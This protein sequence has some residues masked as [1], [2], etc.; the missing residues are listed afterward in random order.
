M[1]LRLTLLGTGTPTPSLERG[2]GSFLVEHDDDA[3]LF[4]CG[5]GAVRRLLAA[6]VPPTRVTHLFLTHLHYDH[7]MDYAYLTLTRWDQ[8]AGQIPDLEVYGPAGTARMTRLLFGEEGAYQAD[9]AGRTLHP[10]SHII[11]EHRGG[12][13]PRHRPAPRVREVGAGAAIEGGGWQARTAEMVHCQPYLQSVAYRFESPEGSIVVTGD[14]APNPQ[15]VELARG[16]NVLL[17]MCHFLNDVETDPRLTSSCS[18][19]LDA[20]RTAAAA[21][22]ETLV[23]IHLTEQIARPGIRERMVAEAAAVFDGTI[24]LGEDLMEIPL[25]PIRPEPIL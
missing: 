6:G 15:L 13:L 9:L 14:T 1:P 24:I 5:P 8:G 20:A 3:L 16:A 7:C 17:Q 22:V 12:T 2:G 21:G 10:G 19:H 11:Y 25:G 4:D 23:L 18:G